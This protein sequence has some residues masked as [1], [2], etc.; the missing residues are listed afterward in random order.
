MG[1]QRLEK[2]LSPS[3]RPGHLS[4]VTSAYSGSFSFYTFE[5][6]EDVDSSGRVWPECQAAKCPLR[7]VRDEVCLRGG[8]RWQ[9]GHPL[10]PPTTIPPSLFPLCHLSTSTPCLLLSWPFHLL[11][12]GA[13]GSLLEAPGNRS[14]SSLGQKPRGQG[15][16]GL[17]HRIPA[18][19]SLPCEVVQDVHCT[20]ALPAGIPVHTPCRRGQSV[21]L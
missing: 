7:Q 15:S 13:L 9:P 5:F 8:C 20:R 16:R 18:Q 1:E 4:L 19:P 10:P 21:Y 3:A 17:A 14:H 6:F 12:Q 2:T 11:H